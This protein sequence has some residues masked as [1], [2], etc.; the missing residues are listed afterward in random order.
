[1]AKIL[2]KN[3]RV[4]DGERFLYADILTNRKIIEK[5]ETEISEE[6]D[7]VYDAK[8]KTVSSGLVDA[9]AHIKGFSGDRFSTQAEMCCFPFGVTSVADAGGE[10]GDKSLLDNF[11]INCVIFALSVIEND[12]ADIQKTKE[13]LALFGENAVGLKVFFD[14]GSPNVKSIVPLREICELAHSKG[15]RVLVHCSNSPTKMSE[16]LD[17]LGEGD[18]L[19]HAF[20]GGANNAAEDNFESMRQAQKRGVFID[21]GYAGNY[22]TDFG[23]LELALKNGI[24]PDVISTDM[25]KQLVYNCGGRYG[26]TMC[27]SIAR[28]LGMNEEDIFRAVTSNPAR[29]LSK[30]GEWGYL[31][32]G[33]AA[34]IAVLDYTDEGFDLTDKAGNRVHNSKGYRCVMTVSNG[35]IVYKD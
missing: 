35:R 26:M 4:W 15:L 20:H 21:V 9:H 16:I 6:A 33:H 14:A 22:H 23:V 18:I 24:V 31:Q 7:I 30:D 29:A 3:G 8:G 1:M 12:R 2:I 19:T 28:T 10:K 25:T 5:I 32:V 11:V 13:R 17:T 27:M 34:D